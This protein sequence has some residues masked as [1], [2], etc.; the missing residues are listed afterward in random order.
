[1]PI[2]AGQTDPFKDRSP[3]VDAPWERSAK[4]IASLEKAG[5]FIVT[6]AQNNTEPDRA[7]LATLKK[8]C[9]ANK[10]KLIIIPVRYKNPTQ[11]SDPSEEDGDGRVWWHP[12]LRPYLIEQEIRV[13]PKLAIM[14]QVKIQATSPWPLRDGVWARSQDRSAIY[15]HPQLSMVSA[16]SRGPK[17]IYTTGAV[18][19]PNYSSTLA[20][21]LA[22]FHH[23]LAAIVVEVRGKRFHMREVVWDGDGFI[24]IDRK[25]T[26][27]SAQDA[28]RALALV[29]GDTHARFAD[30]DVLEATYGSGGITE[31]IRPKALIWHDVFDAF[32]VNPFADRLRH[33]AM[34]KFGL[35]SVRDELDHLCAFIARYTPRDCESII[36]R[37]NHNHWLERWVRGELRNVTPENLKLWLDLS[38]A[39]LDGVKSG[40]AGPEFPDPLAL[41][42]TRAGLKAR[43]LEESESFEVAGI[44]L[45]MHGHLGPDG[46][47][48]SARLLSTLG[49]RSVVGHSHSPRLQHGVAQVGTSSKLRLGYN[50]GPSSWSHTHCAIL[51]NG[52]RQLLH[53]VGGRFRG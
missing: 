40:P 26:P 36:V 22:E 10:A 11:R 9:E 1:M 25:Y 19:I 14:G 15:G 27:R 31:T 16:P 53:I 2:S 30:P 50:T 5:N 41:Y 6:C 4:D 24:D 21:N 7:F 37:S 46:K 48:G 51:A 35:L 45:G 33:A 44:E 49:Y 38:H 39:M 47:R 32:A 18:T 52:K 42:C 17:L 12:D 20:G 29:T 34:A 13:H 43:W 3:Y 23:S 8:F 28:P